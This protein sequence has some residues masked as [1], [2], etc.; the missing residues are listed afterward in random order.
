MEKKY[1]K[2]DWARLNSAIRDTVV[3]LRYR[4]DY[5]PKTRQMIQSAVAANDLKKFKQLMSNEKYWVNE[6]GV[7]KD[8]F[9]RRKNA[10]EKAA[11]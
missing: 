4:G 8:R 2:T 5:T 9:M 1:G 6:R 7:P 10:L 11:G 3:D